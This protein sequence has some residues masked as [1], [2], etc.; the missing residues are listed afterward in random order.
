M[1]LKKT[2]RAGL[3]LWQV[4]IIGIAYM[5]PMTVFDTFGI[6]SSITEGRV[7]LAYLLA[8]AA[9]L[10]TAISYGRMVRLHPSSG[11]AYTYTKKVCGDKAGFI[12]GWSS[13]LD[14]VF[15]PMINSLLAGIYLQTLLPEIPVWLSILVFTALVTFVNCC[16]IKTLANANFFFVGV[17]VILM[18]VFIYFVIHNLV[19]DFGDTHLFT[20][21]PLFN[22][23]QSIIPLISGA[24][25]LC[26][27][28]L[29]FDAVTTL[30]DETRSPVK[31]IPKAVFCTALSGG[32]IFFVAA[33]FIQLY[34]PDNAAFKHPTEALPEIVLYVGGKLFQTLFLIAILLNTFASA[35]ASHASAARLLHI[36]G[37]NNALTNRFFGY[38]HPVN[39]NPVYC[40]LFIGLVSL[41][42]IFIHLDTAVS[43]ISFGALVAFSAVNL[44]VI[45]HFT[46]IARDN[47][48]LKK[49]LFNIIL[50]L[51]GLG[52]V[53]I[54]WVNLSFDAFI[55]GLTWATTGIGWLI[56]C[57]YTKKEIAISE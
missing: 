56:Y 33:W 37:K 32:C 31:T 22:G 12:V 27:S 28:F 13:L 39:N 3:S 43:L 5:T 29:G 55:L 40:I 50:P 11:S 26:F 9:V 10:L 41:T 25:V 46:F 6:V 42:A 38:L 17:P 24:A 44:S 47:D 48:G 8:L 18:G 4:V 14:Y 16:N 21:Q 19:R 52:C 45:I 20:M 7:P 51:A 1:S 34:F 23:N 15:L 49:I 30:S 53:A 36:M 35:L 54:M 57:G 2:H